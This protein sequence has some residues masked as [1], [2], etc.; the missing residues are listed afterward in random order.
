MRPVAPPAIAGTG[1]DAAT[2]LGVVDGHLLAA[3]TARFT[4]KSSSPIAARSGRSTR[5][6]GLDPGGGRRG[7]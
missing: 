2:G 4:K 1:W 3:L 6:S 7:A 5:C